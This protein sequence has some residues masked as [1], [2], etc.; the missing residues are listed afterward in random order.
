MNKGILL[1]FSP[2]KPLLYN[3]KIKEREFKVGKIQKN[4]PE[5]GFLLSDVRVG[6]NFFGILLFSQLFFKDRQDS[7]IGEWFE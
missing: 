1:K 4:T 7:F 6:W 2:T 3:K 5:S